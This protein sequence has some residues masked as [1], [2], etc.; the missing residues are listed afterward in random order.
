MSC[1]AA[2]APTRPAYACEQGEH[3]RAESAVCVVASATT[4][5]EES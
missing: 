1:T 4:A 2:S 3:R 5:R